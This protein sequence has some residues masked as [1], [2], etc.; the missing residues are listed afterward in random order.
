MSSSTSPQTFE[1]VAK[2]IA[3]TCDIE[4]EKITLESHAIEDLAIDSLAFLDLAFA[5]DKEF[6]IKLP[7]EKWTQEVNDGTVQA[8]EYFVLQNLCAQIDALVAQRSEK[9]A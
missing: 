1:T 4:A 3:E 9:A 6:Q 8:E 5:I 7:L 2:L